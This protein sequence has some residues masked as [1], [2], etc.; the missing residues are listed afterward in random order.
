MWGASED[1]AGRWSTAELLATNFNI[2]TFGED[3]AGELYLAHRPDNMPGAVY[4]IVRSEPHAVP[5]VTGLTT[6]SAIA[7]DPG[8]TL[9]VTGPGFAASAVARWNGQDR[10]TTFVS[11]TGPVNA[12]IEARTFGS[13]VPI[14]GNSWA[15]ESRVPR[16]LQG[17]WKSGRPG[18]GSFS[19]LLPP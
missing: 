10:A 15:T 4:R 9:L 7:G 18:F 12:S 5:A 2:S 14:L 1:S 11:R 6:A 19:G 3:E 16:D 17:S 13:K 8:F